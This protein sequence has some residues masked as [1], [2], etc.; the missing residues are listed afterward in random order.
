MTSA[1]FQQ[2]LVMVTASR[3]VGVIV[4]LIFHKAESVL[5]EGYSLV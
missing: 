4:V 5:D 2:E 1:D 3:G